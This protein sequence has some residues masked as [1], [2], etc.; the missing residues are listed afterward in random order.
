VYQNGVWSNKDYTIEGT[1]VFSDEGHWNFDGEATNDFVEGQYT[2]HPLTGTDGKLSRLTRFRSNVTGDANT[3]R[4]FDS[5]GNSATANT[6]LSLQIRNV[7]ASRL[8]TFV[9][10]DAGTIIYNQGW[11]AADVVDD[12]EWHNALHAMD[13]TVSGNSCDA[14]LDGEYRT[15]LG[16][17]NAAG[18]ITLNRHR[19]GA[20]RSGTLEWDGDV[21]FSADWSR[22]LTTAEGML[23]TSDQMYGFIT[24]RAEFATKQVPAVLGGFVESRGG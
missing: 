1:P 14:F 19:V 24:K 21:E 2:A 12:R 17:S 11:L 23:A 8:Q 6:V 5:L 18:T 22:K 16:R 10:D 4:H 7:D 13:A 9:R 15:S 20:L 3:N